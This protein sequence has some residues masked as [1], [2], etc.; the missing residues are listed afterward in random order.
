MASFSTTTRCLRHLARIRICLC[1]PQWLP[2]LQLRRSFATETPVDT[3]FQQ[4]RD[5]L[6]NRKLPSIPDSATVQRTLMLHNTISP[7]LPPYTPDARSLGEHQIYFNNVVPT[8]EL[9]SDGLDTIH[10]PGHPYVRRMWAGGS[11]QLNV[12]PHYIEGT[13]TEWKFNR[14]LWGVE[15]IKEV[16]KRGQAGDDEKIFVTIE[17]RFI[18]R[19]AILKESK[20]AETPS[21]ELSFQDIHDLL[22]QETSDGKIWDMATLVEER[23][24]VFMKEK[25]ADELAAFRAGKMA[26][27]RYL[28]SPGEPDFSHSLT[29]TPTLLFRYSALTFNAHAIHLDP[30]YSRNVEGYRERL[31]HGPLLLTLLLKFVESHLPSLPGPPHIMQS[32]EYRI[33]APLHCGEEM[34]LCARKKKSLSTEDSIIYDVWIEGPTGGMAVKGMIRTALKPMPK[35]PSETKV[36]STGSKPRAS[37]NITAP[38]RKYKAPRP[39]TWELIPNARQPFNPTPASPLD[40]FGPQPTS[41]HR[42]ESWSNTATSLPPIKPHVTRT[43][44]RRIRAKSLGINPGAGFTTTD[45]ALKYI[46]EPS[47]KPSDPFSMPIRLGRNPLSP[48]RLVIPREPVEHTSSMN[49]LD[50]ATRSDTL[51]PETNMQAKAEYEG[52]PLAGVEEHDANT[53][54]RSSRFKRAGVTRVAPLNV[55][56]VPVNLPSYKGRVGRGSR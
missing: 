56:P 43:E 37:A 47:P 28:D 18:R 22:K 6:L 27:L 9:L 38:T 1:R 49:P 54:D 30:E 40:A 5:E 39:S 14:Q 16:Q 53:A 36:D 21:S 45:A 10:S 20:G 34:R 44:K 7:F 23:N 29:P 55:R 12:S 4:V 48:L 50:I 17:R 25:S 41:T 8:G 3:E 51:G 32:I 15:R 52:I 31:V 35:E 11:I 2:P 13:D 33:F 19:N 26:S 24:L 46:V 42:P